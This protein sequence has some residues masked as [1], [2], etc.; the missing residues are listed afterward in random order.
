MSTP[1]AFRPPGEL[2][3]E[4][5]AGSLA[6]EEALRFVDPKLVA[7]ASL[8]LAAD[9]AAKD[10]L[11]GVPAGTGAASGHAAFRAADAVAFAEVGVPALLVAFETFPE[12]I[13]AMKVVSGVVTVN[14]GLTG[15]AGVVSRGLGKPC[16]ASGSALDLRGDTIVV[17]TTPKVE[18]SSGERFSFDGKTGVIVAGAAAF[19]SLSDDLAEVL[20]WADAVSGARVVARVSTRVDAENARRMGAHTICVDGPDALLL[21]QARRD[22][23]LHAHAAIAASDALVAAIAADFAGMA[24]GFGSPAL[25][26]RGLRLASHRAPGLEA[27][28]EKAC[29][30]AGVSVAEP[31]GTAPE[32][33]PA[34]RLAA[35]LESLR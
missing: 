9:P 14:G 3:R 31:E 13:E 16:I 19:M 29:A 35:A 18:W 32:A 2:L 30:A 12:D 34:R 28:F 17:R 11:R 27:S 25:E 10:A 23:V 21:G 7:P 4:V 26:T 20:A 1:R 22:L 15:H 24:S 33:V 8:G 5:R 6:R